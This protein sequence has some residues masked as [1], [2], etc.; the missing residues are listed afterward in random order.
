VAAALDSA[1]YEMGEG[2]CLLGQE[3]VRKQG[4]DAAEEDSRWPGLAELARR[5]GIL[6]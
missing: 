6:S 1:Q 5:R 4:L 3:T 2:P